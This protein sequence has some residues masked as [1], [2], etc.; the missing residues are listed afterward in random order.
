MRQLSMSLFEHP[1]KVCAT[2]GSATGVFGRLF[3][4]AETTCFEP[5]LQLPTL[6][7]L[8]TTEAESSFD[9]NWKKVLQFSIA[10]SI[11][12]DDKS[13]CLPSKDLRPSNEDVIGSSTMKIAEST[14]HTYE[15]ARGRLIRP[16]RSRSLGSERRSYIRAS[17]EH[18][19]MMAQRSSLRKTKSVTSF[20]D[21]VNPH[22]Q[23]TFGAQ[24]AKSS[25]G[26]SCDGTDMSKDHIK[27]HTVE[28]EQVSAVPQIFVDVKAENAE[29]L[30]GRSSPAALKIFSICSELQPVASRTKI[31]IE[32]STGN[33]ASLED[34][35]DLA[36]KFQALLVLNPSTCVAA[37]LKG[38]RCKNPLSKSTRAQI[39]VVLDSLNILNALQD[40]P[41]LLEQLQILARLA[42][43]C[44]RHQ[45]RETTDVLAA[46]ESILAD[47]AGGTGTSEDGLNA[48][49]YKGIKRERCSVPYPL[50]IDAQRACIRRFQRYDKIHNTRVGVEEVLRRIVSRQLTRRDIKPGYLYIYNFPGNFGLVK[51]GV[52]T[53]KPEVR[54]QGWKYQC[55]HTPSLIYP[56]LPDDR[57]LLAHAFRLEALVHAELRDYRRVELQCGRCK[58]NHGE[59][60]ERT[61]TDVVAVARK[62]STWLS[63][64]PYE[65][66][67]VAQEASVVKN[68]K[69]DKSVW[70]LGKQH[71]G[72][73]EKLCTITPAPSLTSLLPAS[74]RSSLR[75]SSS[76]GIRRNLSPRTSRMS[77]PSSNRTLRSQSTH[78][79]KSTLL[80]SSEISL[81]DRKFFF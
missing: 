73:G 60:F 50:F 81:T 58:R 14:H 47:P 17:S 67:D 74:G 79:S 20:A 52:T 24:W 34:Y 22:L 32:E 54:M 53:L 2:K 61:Y 49:Q 26:G 38:P 39:R 75:S 71:R 70:R 15:D 78:D 44:H 4:D 27:A 76:P 69:F 12:A 25:K 59:W 72:E 19:P 11:G 45:L 77:L 8:N 36:D 1:R 31:C 65:E 33:R 9:L 64:A 30:N 10:D 23:P 42:L 62:W 21:L 63:L 5:E 35:R 6:Q 40:L 66:V 16:D 43:C 55:G 48:W 13:R 37:T 56:L 57:K 18:G 3:S 80:P 68:Q 7:L 29:L 41:V 46:S 51:V 28:I